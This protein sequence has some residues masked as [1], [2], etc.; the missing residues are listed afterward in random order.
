MV[1]IMLLF[2]PGNRVVTSL[3]LLHRQWTVLFPISRVCPV[4]CARNHN[5]MSPFE[6]G[7]PTDSKHY[8]SGE[9]SSRSISG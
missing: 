5:R 2:Q 9:D 4:P 6:R 8:A 1:V 7:R 3:R